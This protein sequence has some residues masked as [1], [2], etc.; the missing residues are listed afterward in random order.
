MKTKHLFLN[1]LAVL[2]VFPSIGAFAQ[3]ASDSVSIE[4]ITTF[5]YPGDVTQTIPEGINDR[6][7]ITG[8]IIDSSGVSRGFVRFADGAFSPPIVE[9]ND[10]M[11]HTEGRGITDQRLVCGWYTG[12]DGFAHGYFLD[13]GAFT[14]FNVSGAT[15]DTIVDGLNDA[16]D[17]VGNSTNGGSQA[18][19]FSNIDGITATIIIPG[20]RGDSFAYGINRLRQ[21][22]GGYL[23]GDTIHGWWQD[24][25]GTV[26]APFDPPG[27]EQTLPFGI[28]ETGLVVGRFTRK[29]LGHGFLFRLGTDR[30]LVFDYPGAVFTSLGGINNDG[31]ICGRYDD[32]SG[33][34]HGFLAQVVTGNNP[35]SPAGIIEPSNF[36]QRAR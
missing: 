11:G 28:N 20:D 3:Q 24:S 4:V 18:R 32:G 7:D 16:G 22:T 15:G 5:D 9:P 25:D 35:A 13:R 8:I 30:F 14:E 17:F 31:L 33:L 19:A 34:L 1:I 6:G 2:F 27:S 23:E 12:S 29:G 26:Y 21:I 10:T 36:L